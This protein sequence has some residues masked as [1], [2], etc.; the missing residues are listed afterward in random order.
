MKKVLTCFVIGMIILFNFTSATVMARSS[1]MTGN[2]KIE[3][4]SNAGGGGASSGVSSGNKGGASSGTSSGNTS[5]SQ[6]Q[7]A[8][9]SKD[10]WGHATNWFN[11]GPSASSTT[12]YGTD[13][14]STFEE[15]ILI[16][17]TT[18]IVIATIYLG[19][20]MMFGSVEARADSKE[21]LF[22]LLV[23]CIFFFGWNSLKKLLIDSDTNNLVFLSGSNSNIGDPVG[24][25][26]VSITY[27]LQFAAI[28][29]I[30]YVGIKYIFAGV[31]GKTDL[32][33]KSGWFLIG[34]IL[35]FCSTGFLTFIS[36]II[37]QGLETGN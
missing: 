33:E 32:K 22:N 35:A 9:S 28:I 21:G 8:E 20:K 7:G 25:I 16:V 4:A 24:R 26:F 12:Q 11:T 37:I 15:M 6:G 2:V 5:N 30:I 13:I 10:F 19:V 1:A 34:I 27:V 31:E 36:D 3:I 23:A 17:G 18:V 29:G 14:I